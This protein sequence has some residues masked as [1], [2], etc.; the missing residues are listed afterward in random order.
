MRLPLLLMSI[1]FLLSIAVDYYLYRVISGRCKAKLWRRVY[2]YS[3]IGFILFL[4]VVVCLP[5]RTGSDDSLSVIMWSLFGYMSVYLPKILCAVVDMIACVPKIWKGKRVK[6]LTVAGVL[7]SVVLC[8]AMW[9]GALINR[10]TL[11]VEEVELVVPEWPVKYD[12]YKIVQFSDLHLGT[13]KGDTTF[14]AGI[15]EVIN[16]QHPDAIMFTGDIVNRR[17]EEL[18]PYVNTL[19]GLIAHDGV[20][21]VLGN[22]D[23]G[24]YVNWDSD[25]LKK[26]NLEKLVKLQGDMGWKLLR[27]EHSWLYQG[28]TDSLLIVGVENWG[29]APFPKYGS[30]EKAYP[31]MGD[32]VNKILLTH[33]PSH[34]ENEVKDNENVNVALTLSGH[35]HA[36]QISAGGFSPASWR[37][38]KWGGLYGDESGRQKLYVNIGIGTVG[39]PMRLGATPEITVIT[40]RRQH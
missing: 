40:I 39:I 33:N 1:V 9:W 12:N 20:Y 29:D 37:F 10:F 34:W 3:S 6:A 14:I 36:M 16:R 19:S 28:W 5:R 2:L 15:V 21:S 23:Y 13:Y 27:N 38:D 24:D 35:T 17:A 25:S 32:N 11:N 7:L 4:V 8:G 31:T 22:H 30:L 26:A 18:E